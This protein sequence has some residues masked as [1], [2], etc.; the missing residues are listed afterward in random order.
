MAQFNVY[1][2]T[3]PCP[4]AYGIPSIEMDSS[5]FVGP[6]SASFPPAPP[7][8]LFLVTAFT[9]TLSS[10]EFSLSTLPEDSGGTVHHKTLLPS[11]G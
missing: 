1:F 7:K 6:T 4:L 8:S 5:Y 2:S 9:N 11:L 10:G 3:R